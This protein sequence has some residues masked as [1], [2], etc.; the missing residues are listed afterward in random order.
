M[1]LYFDFSCTRVL[2]YK[3][4]P[5]KRK[6][7]NRPDPMY[8]KEEKSR[9]SFTNKM[10]I[11]VRRHWSRGRQSKSYKPVV[12]YKVIYFMKEIVRRLVN[13]QVFGTTTAT[14]PTV[15]RWRGR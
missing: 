12:N 4:I 11:Q 3:S 13:I 8:G 7:W 6:C 10:N 9:S 14:V 15:R 2:D 5:Q 1:S